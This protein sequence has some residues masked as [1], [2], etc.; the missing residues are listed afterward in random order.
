MEIKHSSPEQQEKNA[1]T[2]RYT[3]N[4]AN[5]VRDPLI[6]LDSGLKVLFANQS[7]YSKFH[8]SPEE[9]QGRLIYELG[10]RQWDIPEL[11]KLLETILPEHKAFN[12]YE[13]SHA[14]EGIGL[15]TMLLNAR[16]IYHGDIGQELILL[17][18]EDITERKR[19]EEELRQ[20]L[21][22][23][24]QAREELQQFVNI[25]SHDLKS[26]IST[27]SNFAALILARHAQGLDEKAT[28]FIRYI[29]ES[30]LRLDKLIKD[31]LYYGK[32][33]SRPRPFTTVDCHAV[34]KA[35]LS[36]LRTEVEKTK[37]QII[38]GGCP[39]MKGDSSLLIQLFQNLL[40]NALKYSDRPPRIEISAQLRDNEWLF[41]FRDNG[42]GIAPENQKRIFEPFHPLATGKQKGTGL[43]LSISRKIVEM[44]GGRIWVESVPGEGSTF[45]FTLPR[46]ENT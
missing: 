40:A 6:V 19:A 43:G 2:R 10:N 41:S 17:A 22:R 16:Q 26:P 46:A 3:E 13:V 7:F 25:M 30:T 38:S 15:R 29:R 28:E 37:A 8:V 5:T 42:I 12:D 33:G 4:I 45:Y 44:H 18:I 39:A 23:E 24:R 31:L 20:A 11:R 21:A 9:T 32:V 36:N 35:A 34:L 27:I 1:R 14:F